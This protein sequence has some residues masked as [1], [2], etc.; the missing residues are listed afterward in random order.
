M[1]NLSD[2]FRTNYHSHTFRCHHAGGTEEAYIQTAIDSGFAV[3]GF[4]DHTPWPYADG[5]VSG[6]RMLPEELAEYV[7]TV[8]TLGETYADRIRVLCGLEC[9][10]YPAMLPW[11]AE[12]KE[13]F[14]LDYLIFGNHFFAPERTSAYFGSA[15]NREEVQRYVRTSIEALETGMFACFAHPDLVLQTM[16]GWNDTLKD[17]LRE[18]C[19]AAKALD[20]PLEYNL[21]GLLKGR[22]G[23]CL[24]YPCPR[25]WEIA[26]EE[27]CTAIVGVDAHQTAHMAQT[28]AYDKAY[29]YL[30]SLG[31]PCV[32]ELS[33]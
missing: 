32:R 12:R 18:L 13:R 27:G 2:P 16:H 10:Y 5:F 30:Q 3:L 29:A 21:L 26:A 23:D 1:K 24:G 9:E 7:R 28:E 17:A 22:Q 8:R 33:V 31:M 19:R 15:Q 4:S 6:V 11:L 25:F 20:I 14:G